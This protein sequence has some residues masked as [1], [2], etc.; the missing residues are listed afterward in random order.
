[1]RRRG[2]TPA[3]GYALAAIRYPDRVAIVD[4][5]GP[6][7]FA[8][9]D[10]RSEALASAFHR[11]GIGHRDTVAIMCRNHRWFVEATVACRRL[12][13]NMLYLDAEDTPS[14]LAGVVASENPHALI[15]DEEFS[16]LLQP[17]GRGRRHFIAWCD[18]D[19]PA[20]C[21]VL[22]ELIAREG[23]VATTPPRNGRA[24]TVLLPPPLPAHRGAQ[25]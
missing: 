25:P 8:E 19:R 17:V 3:A 12:G 16:E 4:D 1:V 7:T 11:A 15:Y 10:R 21:P 9:V 14:G 13:A 23:V 18:R 5:R 22:E 6:L 2:L 20:R 24:S